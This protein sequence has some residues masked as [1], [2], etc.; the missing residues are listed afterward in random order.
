MD[1]TSGKIVRTLLMEGRISRAL[2]SERLGI[3]RAA[4]SSVTERLIEEKVLRVSGIGESRG[5]KPPVML[6]IEPNAFHVIGIDIGS[7][8]FLRGLRCNAAGGEVESAVFPFQNTFEDILEKSALLIRR[9]SRSSS[10]AGVA[11]VCAAVSGIVDRNGNEVRLSANFPLAGKQ[12]ADRLGK[13]CGYEIL[14]ENRSRVSA[15]CERYFGAARGCAD[16]LFVTAEKSIGSTLY[17]NGTLFQG[18]NGAAGE[19]RSIPVPAGEKVITLEKALDESRILQLC[20]NQYCSEQELFAGFEREE[21]QA[22]S[23]CRELLD[24]AAGGIAAAVNL[25]DPELVIL[26]GR[27]RAFGNRFLHEFQT[28][29]DR[30]APPVYGKRRTLYSSVGRDGALRGAALAALLKQTENM[31]FFSPCGTRFFRREDYKT[32][33]KE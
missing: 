24:A 19:I 16:F 6:S 26:G 8:T 31:R 9:L 23:I 18:R 17:S 25:T 30:L 7:G 13:L 15:E 21:A 12:F 4:V 20:G 10:E 3:S 27:F 33:K 5:G 32:K 22:V 29:L 2:L 14:L 28:R 11:G 1:S